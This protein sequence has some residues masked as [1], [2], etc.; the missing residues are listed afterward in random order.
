MLLAPAGTP[1]PIVDRLHEEMNR[2]T[3]SPEFLDRANKLGLLP[4]DSPSVEE[5]Q[6][7]ID[8]E[9]QK[10]GELLRKSGLAGSQ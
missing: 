10:W 4:I 8:K 3:R 9:S 1:R 2:L 7:F 5:M 6:A